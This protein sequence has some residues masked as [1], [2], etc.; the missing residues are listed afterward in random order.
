MAAR[1]LHARCGTG[2][3]RRFVAAFGGDEVG[4]PGRMQQQSLNAL[5]QHAVH[6]GDTLMLA[7]VLQ[8]GFDQERFNEPTCLRRIFENAPRVGTIPATFQGHALESNEKGV[9]VLLNSKVR[10]G[11]PRSTAHFCGA[12]RGNHYGCQLA[13]VI[14]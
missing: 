9:A 7:Q 1:S 3:L 14:V 6:L 2:S 5:L 12:L 8:P 10:C 4:D 13:E 11:F